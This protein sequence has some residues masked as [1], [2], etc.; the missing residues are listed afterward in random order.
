MPDKDKDRKDNEF[1]A[2]NLIYM[3]IGMAALAALGVIAIPLLT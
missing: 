3:I 2:R 1:P